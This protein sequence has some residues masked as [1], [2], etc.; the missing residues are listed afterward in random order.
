MDENEPSRLPASFFQRPGVVLEEIPVGQGVP[1]GI[2][3]I[4]H[5][6]TGIGGAYGTWGEGYD[7][8][9]LFEF[10][11]QKLGKALSKEEQMDLSS[12]GFTSRH[13]TS[14]L[15]DEQQLDLEVAF[16]ARLLREAANA[17]GWE[18]GEVEGVLIGTSAPLAN[19]YTHRIASQAG[20]P[21]SALKISVHKA[22]DSSVGSLH[23]A[24]NPDLPENKRL[25]KN[26]ARELWGKKI[27]VGGI[28]GLSRFVQRSRDIFAYQL[29]GNGAGVIGVIPGKTLKF[30]VGN[31]YEN[32]DK[33]GVLS[34][35]MTY[36]H[37]GKKAEGESL[38]DVSDTGE[39]DFHISG[40]MHE[41]D[42]GSSINMAGP[43][44]MVKLF[45]RT[46]VQVVRDVYLAYQDLK[47][48][49]GQFEKNIRVTVVHHA[50][51][52]I[53][54]LKAKHLE[55]EGIKLSMP[56]IV[57]EF[58]NVSAASNMIAFL[59]ELPS[60]KP[61]DHILIDGF[62]AGTYYDVLAVDIG[63]PAS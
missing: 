17:S 56:W 18:T 47:N 16:G 27:L 7:N 33:Q 40:L 49:L 60:F 53:N 12:L 54:A 13:H 29:F 43:M 28:E 38:L 22:C 10:I 32:F 35:S 21:E 23:L 46:G 14:G 37:S 41:P 4:S 8:Q 11:S 52:K 34:V 3:K 24:M 51:K 39:D 63:D 45:V 44:G 61:G 1:T 50:N 20:V 62:G 19:D 9:S 31:D 58:G 25:K 30:L 2:E 57:S 48:E 55:N 59:R 5:V 42:D 6:T 26:I 15:S 36:P